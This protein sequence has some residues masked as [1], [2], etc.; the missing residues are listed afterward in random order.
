MK[1]LI[2]QF[3]ERHFDKKFGGTKILDHTIEEFEHIINHDDSLI[4]FALRNHGTAH[5]ILDHV[6]VHDGYAPFCKLV[7]VRNFTNARV[8]SLPKT[9]ENYSFIRSGYSGRRDTELPIFSRWLELPLAR[10]KAEWLMLVLYSKEQIEKEAN[11]NVA[12]GEYGVSFNGDWGVVAIL[13]QSHSDEEEMK[14][15]TMIR[16]AGYNTEEFQKKAVEEFM[17]MLKLAAAGYTWTEQDV[18][19]V[20]NLQGTMVG[21]SGVPL[22]KDKYL[23]SVD[24]W[25]NN[26]SLK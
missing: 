24:F 10:P 9:L 14:P 7:A 13:G 18:K 5:G 21:G 6:K 3:A 23:K 11:E 15:E 25:D 16:N 8:G 20:L 17:H 12:E 26:I 1:I 4:T 2:T 22:N 19:N